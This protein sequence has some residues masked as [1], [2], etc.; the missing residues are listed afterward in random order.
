MPA[1]LTSRH[2]RGEHAEQRADATFSEQTKWRFFLISQ[3]PDILQ[4][5]CFLP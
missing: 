1:E 2:S 5:L 3:E 4:A